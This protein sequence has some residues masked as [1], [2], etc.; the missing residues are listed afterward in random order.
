MVLNSSSIFAETSFLSIPLSLA[1]ALFKEPR[2]SMAAAAITPLASETAFMPFCFPGVIFIMSALRANLWN[3]ISW[4]HF[5]M[6]GKWEP[7]MNTDRP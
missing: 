4:T 6:G 3:E 1:M 7:Q 2:W 5:S